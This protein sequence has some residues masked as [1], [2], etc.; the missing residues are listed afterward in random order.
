MQ[1]LSILVPRVPK[2][3]PL[4]QADHELDDCQGSSGRYHC[5]GIYS[6]EFQVKA[7]ANRGRREYNNQKSKTLRAGLSGLLATPLL[8]SEI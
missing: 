4:L 6:A 1:H 3:A 2:R 8:A 5:Q 7:R